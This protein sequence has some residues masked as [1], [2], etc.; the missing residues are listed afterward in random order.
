MLCANQYVQLN[1]GA[2]QIENSLSENLLGMI[3]D[4]K[5]SFE[6]HI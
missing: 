5:L 3:I 4:A 2:A 6:K 1:I